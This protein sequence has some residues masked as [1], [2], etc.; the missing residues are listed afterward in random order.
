MN[1][2]SPTDFVIAER[3]PG[4]MGLITLNRPQALNALSL[5]M[6][7]ALTAEL[8]GWQ[9][10][11][12]VKAVAI[13]GM[14]KS[15]EGFAPFG[16]FCAGGDIRF[17]HQAALAGDAALAEFFTAE[18]A[19]NHLIHTYGKPYIAFMD[20]IVMGGGMGL[21]Q[22]PSALAAPSGDLTSASGKPPARQGPSALAASSGELTSAS[23]KPLAR[24]G[25][26][27][28]VVTERTKMAMP[29]TRIGLFPDVGGGYFLSRTP[30]HL[31]EYLA[32]TGHVLK[33]D[34]AVAATLADGCV[35]AAQLP[36][37]WQHLA[38][39]AWPSGIAAQHWVASQFIAASARQI[40]ARGQID[41]Y[42]GLR[43]VQAIVTALEAA[44]SDW[45][46]HTA[47]ELRT[48]SPLMLHV[49]L[50]QVRRA[51]H[52]DLA[53]ELRMERDLVH[54]CFHLREPGASETVEGIR[55]LAVDKD[56][57]PRWHPARI[58]DIT[59][60]MVAPFFVSPWAPQAHPLAAL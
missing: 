10:D 47:Q 26:A 39:T 15:G 53:D 60:D 1:A 44:G 58:E 43:T 22:G 20:G 12:A 17:F 37:I 18:Y 5:D 35:P 25:A 38:D 30:G 4:G 6:I 59:P 7:R 23:G 50:E 24:P 36:A 46:Q 29:E 28:R 11:A 34:E 45:A 13:R 32:L 31:G 56:H 21:C 41:H 9:H 52:M 19:L 16:A 55:A 48:R 27:L 42:F 51:R 57:A 49:T 33:G 54:H 8:R 2:L 40:S 14:G 3:T